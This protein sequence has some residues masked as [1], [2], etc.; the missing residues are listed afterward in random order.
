MIFGWM[1][2]H[3][4]VFVRKSVFDA[5]GYYRT[6]IGSAADFEWML[7]AIKTHKISFHYIPKLA[8]KMRVGGMSSS[9]VK[10]RIA[11]FKGD[12]K[13][14][15]LNG[16]SFPIFQVGIKKLRKISQFF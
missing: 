1:P 7:R 13:A 5:V 15:T 10:S 8:V 3:P 16:Y 4:T 9:G 12:Y 14:W 6:D 2:P 11:A